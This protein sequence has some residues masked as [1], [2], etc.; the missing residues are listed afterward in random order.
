MLSS[1]GGRK[2]TAQNEAR[3]LRATWSAATSLLCCAPG[4]MRIG[5]SKENS[6]ASPNLGRTRKSKVLLPLCDAHLSG[7]GRLIQKHRK[8]FN[9]FES[10]S[11]Y[12]KEDECMQIVNEFS[13]R[14]NSKKIS[15]VVNTSS[16]SVTALQG[17]DLA[18]A[19]MEWCREPAL[20]RGPMICMLSSA[21]SNRK[22]LLLFFFS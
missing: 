20:D 9:G 10:S 15:T 21:H 4:S 17:A 14:N 19:Q 7:L 11:N 8:N 5:Q 16:L 18:A 6:S 12:A 1:K 3:L 13:G 22:R 2:Q